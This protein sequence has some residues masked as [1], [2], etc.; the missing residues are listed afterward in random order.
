MR[1]ILLA[2]TVAVVSFTAAAPV[3]AQSAEERAKVEALLWEKE[4]KIYADRA[5]GSLA[6]YLTQITDNYVGWPPGQAMPSDAKALRERSGLMK[7]NDKEE[8]TMEKTGFTMEGDTA[9]IYY[10]THRTMRPD[11]K[12]ANEQFETIHVYTRSGE[13]WKM[14]GALARPMPG[15]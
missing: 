8:L 12:P 1:L 11:G 5:N 6:Y 10:R 4:Q 13:D 14:I 7:G 2:A 9:V 3:L 15:K